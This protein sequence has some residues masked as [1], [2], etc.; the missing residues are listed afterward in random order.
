MRKRDLFIASWQEVR[1]EVFKVNSELAGIIDEINPDESYKLVISEYLYGDIIIKNGVL[2]L[3]SKKGDKLIS[4]YDTD[5][6]KKIIQELSYKSMPLFLVLSKSN[7]FFIDSGSCI[8][9]LN[10]FSA[11][12]ICGSYERMDLMFDFPFNYRWS[13]SAG[14]RS[15]VM[16][17]K[18]T[19]SEGIKKICFKYGIRDSLEVKK[20][21]NHWELFKS[22][23]Q[24]ECCTQEWKNKI[25]Y[26]GGK[27]FSEKKHS[28]PWT[29]FRNYLS[30]NI[31]EPSR[32][33]ISKTNFG[34]E[35]RKYAEAITS[36]RIKPEIYLLDQLKHVLSVARGDYPAFIPIDDS[37]NLAPTISI[38]NAFI[39]TYG[40]KEY[41]PSILSAISISNLKCN[42][43]VYYSLSLPTLLDG[44]PL[45]KNSSTIMLDL[46]KIKSLIDTISR[47]VVNKELNKEV[48]IAQNKFEYF[49]TEC[50]KFGSILPSSKISELDSRFC[51]TKK[52][53]DERKFCHTGQFFKGCIKITKID[54][55]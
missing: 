16:L 4:I 3:P 32:Y 2:Q 48:A 33:S 17:P 42:E 35:W 53:I 51:V 1:E 22:I 25:L 15:I 27:W 40:L 44:S 47:C 54:K 20:L 55:H 37:Q 12:S 7:E 19:N 24:S 34:L 52:I 29:K 30:R 50:D 8:I 41:F 43:S 23:A 26:F 9:P 45:K 14:S 38:E 10:L 49:H 13:C 31:R 18:I 28:L 36:R 6:D 21:S 11:G 46:R 39:E 5:V